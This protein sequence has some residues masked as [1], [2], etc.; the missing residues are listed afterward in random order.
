MH[1]L[2]VMYQAT[3]HVRRCVDGTGETEFS[4]TEIKEFS[5]RCVIP[6]DTE[7]YRE[8]AL[9]LHRTELYRRD[10]AY[11]VLSANVVCDVSAIMHPLQ[12]RM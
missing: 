8:A 4:H 1:L 9:A 11:K 5:W 7:A 10:S 2:E 3:S 12:R 6:E